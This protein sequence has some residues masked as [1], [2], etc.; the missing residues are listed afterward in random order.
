MRFNI[1]QNEGG[2]SL[3]LTCTVAMPTSLGGNNSHLMGWYEVE[4]SVNVKGCN[5]QKLSTWKTQPLI[6]KM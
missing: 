2:S 4:M 5:L 1:V 3:R 6:Q